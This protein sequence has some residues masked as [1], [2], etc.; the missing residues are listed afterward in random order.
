LAAHYRSITPALKASREQLAELQKQKTQLAGQVPTTLVSTSVAPRAM[1]IL[2]R[3]NWLDDSGEIVNPDVP[4]AFP[5]LVVPKR[6]ANRP[7]LAR[8]LVAPEN[9]LSARV[10]VNRLWLLMF[11]QGIVRTPDD[12]GAQGAWPTHPELLDWLAVEFRESGWDVR[13]MIKL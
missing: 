9:P 13:H 8:W 7:D 11:G 6:R 12:F 4:A 1:R 3:G 5:P 2:P 10:F